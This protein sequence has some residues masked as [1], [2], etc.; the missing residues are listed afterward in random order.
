MMYLQ[1]V[2]NKLP[3]RYTIKWNETIDE[4]PIVIKLLSDK[5]EETNSCIQDWTRALTKF[6][7][8]PAKFTGNKTHISIPYLGNTIHAT[9]FKTG[10]IML[11]GE[12]RGRWAANNLDEIIRTVH[13][14]TKDSSDKK[15]IT[16]SESNS[17]SKRLEE[18]AVPAA[19][20][21]P[22]SSIAVQ[23]R[24][25]D[26]EQVIPITQTPISSNVDDGD[27]HISSPVKNAHVEIHSTP[28]TSSCPQIVIPARNKYIEFLIKGEELSRRGTICRGQPKVKSKNNG[29][30][31]VKEDHKKKAGSICWHE[32]AEWRELPRESKHKTSSPE[33]QI[34][35]QTSEIKREASRGDEIIEMTLKTNSEIPEQIFPNEFVNA[36]ENE[37]L[38]E[39]EQTLYKPTSLPTIGNITDPSEQ[40]DCIAK[41]P[42]LTAASTDNKEPVNNQ[43][44]K[45]ETEKGN[46][47]RSP[48]HTDD[49]EPMWKKVDRKIG[50]NMNELEEI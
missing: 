10:T 39:T 29:W 28:T 11:Q 20:D 13:S 42:Q 50:S 35:S 23:V 30:V 26:E 49:T 22:S 37:N 25:I 12:G 27:Q 3:E 44:T 40:A 9:T 19:P 2:R 33:K 47:A 38:L 7:D 8:R 21:M 31:N 48:E 17:D 34:K 15:V 24:T 16:K 46:I 4:S 6:T 18:K 36:V 43:V 45:Y 32:I 5:S 14:Q 1:Q 41:E